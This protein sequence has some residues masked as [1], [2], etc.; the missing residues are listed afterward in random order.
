M[1]SLAKIPNVRIAAV[2]DIYDVHLDLGKKLADS[3]A[4]T[5]K[6]YKEILDSKDIDAVLIGSPDHWHAPMTLDA[7]AAGKDVY[8]EKPMTRTA[9]EAQA[10][11]DAA[12]KH[13][14]VV[15]VGVQGLTDPSWRMERALADV[16]RRPR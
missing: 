3:K 6:N 13:N 7:L 9:A 14:R 10:V 16:R 12:S 5:T 8:V 4:M 11:V 15:V 2:C 1:Q